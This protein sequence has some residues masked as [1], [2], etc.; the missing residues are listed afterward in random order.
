[1]ATLRQTS[2][3][4]RLALLYVT[5]G[6]LTM[7]WTGIWYHYLTSHQIADD[8]KYYWCTGF[9]LSGLVVFAIGLL[10]G[11][12]GREAQHADVAM[13]EITGATAVAKGGDKNDSSGGQN[14]AAPILVTPV[15][16]VGAA[17]PGAAPPVAQPVVAAVPGT[18]PITTVR[19]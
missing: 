6:A 18:Q 19:G 7:V 9:F 16:G 17:I 8:N 1:M 13:G 15:T 4:T 3:A 12:L 10:I 2:H 5:I 11:R 14:A